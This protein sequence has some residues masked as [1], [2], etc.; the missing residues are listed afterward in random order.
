MIRLAA[1]SLLAIFLFV[2]VAM[3]DDPNPASLAPTPEQIARAKQLVLQLGSPVYRER[4]EA[5]RELFKMGRVVLGVIEATIDE[6]SEP[7]IRERCEMLKP[8]IEAADLNARLK[9]FLADKEGKF[10]HDLPGW[11]KF[12]EITGNTTGGR[13]L[14]AELWKNKLNANLLAATKLSKEEFAKRVL[15]RRIDLYNTTMRYS[16]QGQRTPATLADVVTLLFA[17][18][19]DGVATERQYYYVVTNAL[20]LPNIRTAIVDEKNGAAARKLLIRW[21]DSRTE[22]YEVYSTMS[23]SASLNLKEAPI[24][25]YAEK[26]LELKGATGYYRMY[27]L[28]TLARVGGKEHLAIMK[29]WLKDETVQKVVRFVNN[30]QQQTD[31]QVRDVALAMCILATDQK[32][33]DYGFEMLYANANQNVAMKYSYNNYS[34]A[35]DDKRKAAFKK[36]DEF[37]AKPK[38]EEKK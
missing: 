27:A 6:T 10:A 17:E 12:Q 38:K 35:S 33:E 26:V 15:T 21:M 25:K 31:I 1:V 32:V 14:F 28:T 3:A 18:S 30:V 2:A 37:E 22:M 19:Y 11:I 13:E 24:A 7:E 4:D 20:N 16:P 8:T 23:L 36:W 5:T 9:A 29:K 34:F